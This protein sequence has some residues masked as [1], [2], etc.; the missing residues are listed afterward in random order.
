MNA[1]GHNVKNFIGVPKKDLA[2]ALSR[3]APD[4][5]MVMGNTGMAMGDMEMPMPDNTLMMMTGSG[6]FGP[7]EMGGMF[8]VVKIR[9]DLARDDYKNPQPYKNP[10]GTV[11]HEVSADATVSPQQKNAPAMP[12]KDMK[13]PGMAH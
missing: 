3:L 8:T 12:D 5:G 2:K 6:Q 13:M 9:E 4:V 10:A 7:I 1:M 11:A